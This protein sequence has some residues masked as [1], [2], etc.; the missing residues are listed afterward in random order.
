[1]IV[2]HVQVSKFSMTGTFPIQIDKGHKNCLEIKVKKDDILTLLKCVSRK[3]QKQQQV[4]Q[5]S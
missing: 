4:Q 1:M 2:R 3:L 5:R